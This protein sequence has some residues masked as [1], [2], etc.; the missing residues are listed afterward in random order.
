[1][2]T[3]THHGRETAY[4][5]HE[6]DADAPGLLCIHGSGGT[7]TLWTPQSKLDSEIPVVAIDL[8]GHGSSDDVDA[9][10]G[11]ETLN[12]YTDDMEAVLDETGAGVLV[13]SSLGAAVVLWG[14]LERD[15]DVAGAVLT[16]AGARMAVPDDLL[17][18]LATDFERAVEYLHTTDRLFHA[19]TEDY[20]QRSRETMIGV[21]Q[22]VTE[23]DFRTCHSFDVRHRLDRIDVP[24]VAVVGEHDKL[25]PPWFH[26]YLAEHLQNC[27]LAVI[28]GAAH[29][30][31]VEQPTAFNAI[32]RSFCDRL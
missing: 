8:S 15:L 32:L 24:A 18:W 25:T 1:M 12:A 5:V 29:L 16:G 9:A 22:A 13:G 14:L 7:S 28:E 27:D 31:M 20:A 3:V 23:R 6:R 11:L 2:E 30:A 10:P 21:G 4:R 17:T 26:E 19:P